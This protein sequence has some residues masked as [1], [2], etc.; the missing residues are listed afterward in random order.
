MEYV[1]EVDKLLKL[2][3]KNNIKSK[4]Y[5]NLIEESKNDGAKM[6]KAIKTVLPNSQESE[7][8]SI[9]YIG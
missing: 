6:W 4:Y 8:S 7:I 9:L 3:R 2:G 1:Q 5:C